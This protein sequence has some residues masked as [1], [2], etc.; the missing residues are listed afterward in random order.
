VNRPC[1]R[2]A[3][4]ARSPRFLR[5]VAAVV[6]TA[7]PLLVIPVGAQAATVTAPLPPTAV[8]SDL[9]Y[10]IDEVLSRD[11][12]AM[13]VATDDGIERLSTSTW[14]DE[15]VIGDESS[16]FTGIS[17]S[18]DGS[19]LYAADSANNDIAVIDAATNAITTTFPVSVSPYDVDVSP[20]GH[21]LYVLDGSSGAVL[22]LD[23]ATGAT[24]R[25]I[26]TGA[27]QDS[28][29]S[30]TVTPDGRTLYV[31]LSAPDAN[32]STLEAVDVASG[33]VR[34]IPAVT[35]PVADVAVAPDGW[36]VYASVAGAD[37]VDVVDPVAG[38]VTEAI[39][40]PTFNSVAGL[41]LDADGSTL[42][43]ASAGSDGTDGA[44]TRL[45]RPG[46]YIG[47]TPHLQGKAHVGVDLWVSPQTQD[48][49]TATLQ[50]YRDGVAIPGATTDELYVSKALTGSVITL[51]ITT[52]HVGWPARTWT[53]APSAPVAMVI[54]TM[55]PGVRGTFKVGR[56]V[57]VVAASVR[58]SPAPLKLRF[59]WYAGTRKVQSGRATTLRLTSA[60]RGRRIRVV[61]RGSKSGFPSASRHSRWSTTVR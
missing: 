32:H 18:P 47:W 43:V 10:P 6:A 1:Q 24:S 60:M 53:S 38:A 45:A 5:L 36:T 4:A 22:V 9:A 34:E 21:S 52:H 33:E 40:D 39:T 25:T 11:G 44:I 29:D 7:A 16:S 12:T 30:V 20:D 57:G 49:V 35:G 13:F 14:Q 58:W 56:R 26:A 3:T 8:R 46:S 48:G 54:T 17:L 27:T 61:V 41:A 59:T 55:A 31:A 19:R 15:A 28:A 23:A 2:L 51:A 42:Y 37:V 50:W